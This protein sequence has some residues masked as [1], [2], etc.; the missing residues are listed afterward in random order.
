MTDGKIYFAAL[1]DEVNDLLKSACIGFEAFSPFVSPG[2]LRKLIAARPKGTALS[3][4]TTFKPEHVATGFASP[5]TIQICLDEGIALSINQRLHLKCYCVDS[6]SA[7]IGSANLTDSG[8]SL[9][10][11]ANHESLTYHK[12]LPE[13]FLL[14]LKRIKSEAV[15]INPELGKQLIA[16]ANKIPKAPPPQE[17]SKHFAAIND[18]L[19]QKDYFKIDSL[20]IFKPVEELFPYLSSKSRSAE[21]NHDLN[22][23][24]PWPDTTIS[25]D[26]FIDLLRSRFIQHPF[27]AGFIEYVDR[28]RYFHDVKSF[29]QDGCSDEPKPTLW[30]LTQNTQALYSWITLLA[31]DK[32]ERGIPRHSETLQPRGWKDD[33]KRAEERPRRFD[34][35]RRREG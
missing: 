28:K 11:N 27:I 24:G 3:L 16:N 32:I 7:L 21:A 29:L 8:L 9:N 5:E 20:P 1:F 31:E 23:F 30:A 12:A 35:R 34:Q 13:E 26:A 25:K 19:A 2:T 17:N 6:G 22:A 14:Y 15:Y 10:K 33:P 18:L 4:I